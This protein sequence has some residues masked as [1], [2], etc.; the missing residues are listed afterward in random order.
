VLSVKQAA[1]RAG[2]SLALMYQWCS[3]G[4]LPHHRLGAPGKRG[5]IRISEADLAKYLDSCRRGGKPEAAPETT[6]AAP[7]DFA[8]YYVRV[9]GEVKAKA[10]RR[11]S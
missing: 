4:L 7:D 5:T 11:R 9:M 3:A 8:D 10:A 2:V 1:Q 6:P